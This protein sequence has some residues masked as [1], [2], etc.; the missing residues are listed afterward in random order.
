AQEGDAALGGLVPHAE[1]QRLYLP[2][3]AQR[4]GSGMNSGSPGTLAKRFSLQSAFAFSMRS[5]LEDTKFHQM[6]RGPSIGAPPSS[7]TLA[8][9]APATISAGCAG[10]RTARSPTRSR[11]SPTAASPSAT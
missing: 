6:W 2:V 7:I 11:R 10:L 4:S 3:V 9:P 5:L 8:P 1:R